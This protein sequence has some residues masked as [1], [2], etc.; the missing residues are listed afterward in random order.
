MLRDTKYNS[1]EMLRILAGR[2][3]VL[4]WMAVVVALEAVKL[5]EPSLQELASQMDSWDQA[6]LRPKF[7]RMAAAATSNP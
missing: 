3:D 1:R 4:A 6:L 2:S 5:W 7:S